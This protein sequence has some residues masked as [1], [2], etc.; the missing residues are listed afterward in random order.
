MFFSASVMLKWDLSSM[1]FYIILG[2]IAVVC[3]HNSQKKY[4]SSNKWFFKDKYLS[5]WFF[6]WVII[7]V[8]R[9]VDSPIGGMDASN[10][11]KYFQI[12]RNNYMPE[13]FEH[14]A[15]DILFKYFN[16][17]IRLITSDYHV[18]FIAVYGLMC[19]VFIE[20]C[21]FFC[22]QNV[23]FAPFVLVFFLYL[24]GFSTIRSHLSIVIILI[25]C[26]LLAKE[27][28]KVALFVVL[29]A[30]LVHKAALLYAMCIPFCMFFLKRKITVK[31][32]VI[33]LAISIFS[34][35]MLQQYFILFTADM[36]LSGAYSSYAS[37]SLETSFLDNAWK[38]AFEQMFLG[39]F[40]LIYHTKLKAY[41]NTLSITWQRRIN[42]VYLI[43]IFDLLLIPINYM[44]SIWRGYEYFY[45]PRL[46]LWG[47]LLHIILKNYSTKYQPIL[48]FTF[49]SCF[50]AWMIFR[51]WS[52]WES[53]GLIPYIFE[54][55]R[56]L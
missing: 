15:G 42:I 53:S 37:R 44:L 32:V 11:I 2:L 41:T 51:V 48:S 52:T 50:V 22:P 19:Y 55:F 27:K 3:L 20:F 31:A 12:C 46:I 4:S 10:Y 43:C 56:Y 8:F 28:N 24:R 9:L 49:L 40:I 29:C 47:I 30:A 1:I 23:C 14:F 7:A 35:T 36:D 38:I 26:I 6:V 13:Y 45:L 21:R 16:Q 5:W 33:L 39:L 54:P 25:A 34:S 17:A 18:Y